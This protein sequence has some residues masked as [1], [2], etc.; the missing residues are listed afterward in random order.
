[1]NYE[2]KYFTEKPTNQFEKNIKFKIYFV[3]HILKTIQY[4]ITLQTFFF[5]SSNLLRLKFNEL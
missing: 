2:T 5:K 3:N 1:M 4:A